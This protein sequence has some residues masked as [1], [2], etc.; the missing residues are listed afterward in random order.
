MFSGPRTSVV[1][2]SISKDSYNLV[3]LDQKA[4]SSET[5]KEKG[6]GK[7]GWGMEK[8]EDAGEEEK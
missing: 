3:D 5:V 4:A 7:G 1:L 8:V 2:F 6:Q